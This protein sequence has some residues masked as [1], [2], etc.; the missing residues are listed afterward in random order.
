MHLVSNNAV[1]QDQS[2]NACYSVVDDFSLS[3]IA[4]ADILG[5]YFPWYYADYSTS[6][7]FPFMYHA[8]IRRGDGGTDFQINSKIWYEIE[9]AFSQFC[10]KNAIKVNSIL[11]CSLNL[12]MAHPDY[13]RSDMHVDQSFDHKV[14]IGYI[15]GGESSGDTLVF[16]KKFKAGMPESIHHEQ[17]KG[18]TRIIKRVTPKDNTALCFDGNYY[19]AAE[20]PEGGKRRIICVINFT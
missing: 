9:P 15:T 19:H 18:S 20:F 6:N 7:K 10:A 13:D 5:D 8:V 14:F 4:K 11:R 1:Q 2:Y 16:D 12:V 17:E 3:E